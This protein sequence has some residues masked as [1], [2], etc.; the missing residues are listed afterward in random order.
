MHLPA[1]V[2]VQKYHVSI[3]RYLEDVAYD[4]KINDLLLHIRKQAILCLEKFS[5]YLL[6]IIINIRL[7]IQILSTY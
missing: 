5:Y 3:F 1:F 6:C 7:E 2:F 4:S